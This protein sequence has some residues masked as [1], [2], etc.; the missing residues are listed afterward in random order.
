MTRVRDALE[1][2]GLNSPRRYRTLFF[3]CLILGAGLRLVGLTRGDDGA[4]FHAFH[5]DE[6]TVIQAA[7][8][9]IAPTDPPLTA[10]G[11]V[12]SYVLR[13]VLEVGA[14]MWGWEE[15]G[16][17]RV[18]DRR[19]IYYAARAL[20]VLYSV[21]VLVL[22]WLLGRRYFGEGEAVWAVVVVAFAAGAIQQAHFYIIDGLFVLLST[23]CLWAILRSLEGRDRR[24]YVA[25]G[26]LIG[27]TGGVRLNGVLLGLILLVGWVWRSGRDWR[28]WGAKLD[29]FKSIHLWLAAAAALLT[30][31]AVQ[32]FLLTDPGR[33]WQVHSA[34]DF[35][36]S[37]QV[38]RGEILQPWLL[39]DLHTVP[40][41]HYW[42]HLWPLI[43]GW[44]LT[45]GFAAALIYGLRRAS[46]PHG[47]LLLWCALYF[48][49]VGGL[50]TKSV[51]YLIP[52]LPFLALFAGQLAA[53][54]WRAQVPWQR[55]VGRGVVL[56]VWGH[57]VV[58]GVAFA[59]I[60]AVEDS[61]LQ[62]VRWMDR[63]VSAES[64]IGAEGGG[65]S[66][67]GVLED[68][69]TLMP[70]DIGRLFYSGPYMLCGAQIDH[71]SERLH[72]MEYL[73]LIAENRRA[74]FSAVPELFPVAA[75][76]YERLWG[77][78][79]GFDVAQRFKQYPGVGA[80]DWVDDGAE[81]SFLGYDHPEVL[82]FKLR[83]TEALAAGVARW[84]EDVGQDRHC[85][86]A[87]LQQVAAIMQAGDWHGARSGIEAVVEKY[88]EVKLAHRLAAEIYSQLDE[89]QRAEAALANY[90][91]QEAQGV[92]AHVSSPK[93]IHYAAPSVAASLAH[94][95]LA[96]LALQELRSW[97]VAKDENLVRQL[98]QEYLVVA[99]VFFARQQLGHMEQ[100]L[101]Y[102]DQI[103]PTIAATN[104][105]AKLSYQ[106]GQ[107]EAA[108]VW[109]R[110]S[111]AMD[112]A[113]AEVHRFIGLTILA[114]K[115]EQSQ[116][117][118]HLKRAVELDPTLGQE[119]QQWLIQAGLAMPDE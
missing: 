91:A 3:V 118:S 96:D 94:L 9:P 78:E 57:L 23:A 19:R 61:R 110:K 109:W 41:V 108:L 1:K 67:W 111:L 71:L 116:A 93:M 38:A 4:A 7:L 114:R 27:L 2:M 80:W 30:L 55:L 98:A 18:E 106:R 39:V 70:V 107:L 73:A 42:T 58:Y 35:A 53:A 10:Y 117:L 88:P 8:A 79:L 100:V 95:G 87:S 119:V 24:W 17:E 89:Q 63:H 12:P 76:F 51:R 59:R 69:H 26:V 52:L 34:R 92:M 65:F 25:A 45:V 56:L 44:P 6:I 113:Q 64:Y 28:D 50:V 101:H 90:R 72:T 74:Q 75:G 97:V 29:S 82:L 86:D 14:W 32:P 115:D 37:L 68:R 46:L 103:H 54:L 112:E 21:G 22:L 47:L 15:L 85:P 77:G 13:V 31:F 102:A 48:F 81:P 16:L 99:G 36:F 66:M 11:M 104:I 83:D 43:V 40:Y 60:Y 84:K 20:A 105:L 62:A 33:L 49:I 5:P